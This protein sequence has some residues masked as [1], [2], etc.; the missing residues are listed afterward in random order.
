MSKF[1]QFMKANKKERKN[2]KFAPTK[3]LTDSSGNPLEFEFKQISSKRADELR[4]SCTTDVPVT[5][6][7]NMYRQ[8]V[9]TYRF[10][11]RMI[12]ESIVYPDMYDA[13]LQ[14]SYSVK[15]PEDLLYA[16]V[17]DPGEFQELALWV[18]K[19]NGFNETLNDKVE[20]AKN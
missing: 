10:T 14:D 17:D 7:P 2:E 6:K 1:T 19:F 11:A 12:C 5:G 4:D 15:T 3:S 9:N 18:Q 20:E 13:E 16:M 8:K